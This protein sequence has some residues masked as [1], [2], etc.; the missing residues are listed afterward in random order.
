MPLYLYQAAY[1]SEALAAQIRNPQ[2]RLEL[3][4]KLADSVGGKLVAGGYCFGEY[5]VVEV[6]EAPDDTTAAAIALVVAAGG[7]VRAARTTKLLSGPEWI[8]SL[9]KAQGITSRYQPPG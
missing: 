7:A 3:A 8:E 6:Y 2:D 4:A 1:T 9:R 5:D